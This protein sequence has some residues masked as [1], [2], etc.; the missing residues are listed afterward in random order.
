MDQII[1]T[2]TTVYEEVKEKQVAPIVEETASSQVI[3]CTSQEEPAIEEK[4]VDETK[5]D[6]ALT[7]QE[8]LICKSNLC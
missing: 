7:S 3:D 8:E 4:K 2:V 1:S 6:D 5:N